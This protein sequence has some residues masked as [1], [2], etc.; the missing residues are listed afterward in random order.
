MKAEATF[1]PAYVRERLTKRFSLARKLS[2]AVEIVRSYARVRVRLWRDDLPS[3]LADLR[4]GVPDLQDESP[5]DDQLTAIRLAR[6]IS[7]SLAPLPF[8]SRCLVRSL[9]LC[10][11]LGRRKIPSKL[12][13]GVK[14][15]AKFEAHAWV[16]MSGIALLPGDAEE[17]ERLVEL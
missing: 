12:V 13:I 1:D 14:A 16:E 4:K 3:I 2:L 15:G 9:V 7:R 11:L 8:D 6:P 10:D 17:Y 5:L